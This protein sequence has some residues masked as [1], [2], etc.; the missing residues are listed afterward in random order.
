MDLNAVELCA[1]A[2]K[3]HDGRAQLMDFWQETAE[4]FAP[5]R[6]DFTSELT[7]GTDYAA[8]LME[9][10]PLIVARTFKD[11][12]GSMLRPEGKQYFFHRTPYDDYNDD[13][14]VRDYLD[15][16]SRQLARIVFD[17]VSGAHRALKT[18]DEFFALFG[19]GVLSVDLAKKS[20]DRLHIASHHLRDC[21]WTM[22]EDDRPATMDRRIHL[23]ARRIKERF[24]KAKLHEKIEKAFEKGSDETFEIMHC[25]LSADEYDAYKKTKMRRKPGQKLWASIYVDVR[26]KRIL[27]ETPTRHSFGYV[28]PRWAT[29]GESSYAFSPAVVVALPDARLIQAQATVLLESAEKAVAPPLV[30]YDEAIRGDI[31]LDAAAVT[32][33][34][35]NYDGRTGQPIEPIDLGKNITVGAEIINRTEA[36]LNKA[37]Y[38]DVLRMPDTRQTKS[39]IETQFLIDEYVRS[40]LPLF[41]P[42]ANNY[43]GDFFHECD[44]IVELNGGYAMRDMPEDIKEMELQYQWDN[45]LSQMVDRVKSQTISEVADIANVVASIEQIAAQSKALTRLNPAK[46]LRSGVVAIGGAEYLKEEDEAKQEEAALDEQMQAD[47]AAAMAPDMANALQSGVNAAKAAAEIPDMAD[48]S[49]PIL[50]V[51]GE[52]A[53]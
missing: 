2:Q 15:W 11:Q 31:N 32:W 52:V 43:N 40:A 19:Q 23:T 39:T 7:W 18:T 13:P 35:R 21:A 53:A 22:G 30:A 8:H 38:L 16:R 3:R 48:P 47:K 34:D 41:A 42:M 49:F 6:A 5:W 46:M 20:L 10:T 14:E 9:S 37:F 36:M 26:H 4:Q 51:P 12:I 28:V 33:I 50:P 1:R 24:P 17:R 44:Q 29:L 27:R 25:V 45:P